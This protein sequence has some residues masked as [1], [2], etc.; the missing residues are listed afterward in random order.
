MEY[1]FML[2]MFLYLLDCTYFKITWQLLT[3]TV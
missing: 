2:Y 3:E 1:S